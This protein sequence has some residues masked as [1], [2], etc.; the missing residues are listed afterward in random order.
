MVLIANGTLLGIQNMTWGGAQGF[1]T[2]P[3]DKFFVPYHEDFAAGTLAGAGF[4]GTTHT[5]RGLTWVEVEMA[6]HMV[7][8]FAPFINS[9]FLSPKIFKF[10]RRLVSE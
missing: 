9:N 1:Q 7:R 6:G 10:E 8:I 2:K 4:F 3:S 5:E